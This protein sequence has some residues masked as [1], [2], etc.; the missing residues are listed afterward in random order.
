MKTK[1]FKKGISLIALVATI[2]IIGILLSAIVIRSRDILTKTSKKEFANELY[3]V[4]SQVEKYYFKNSEYPISDSIQIDLS[5]IED[6]DVYQFKEEQGYPDGVI[7]LYKIDL[8]EADVDEAKRGTQDSGS[9]DV[10]AVSQDTGNIYY[11]AGYKSG[12][13]TFY[14]LTDDLLDLI[15]LNK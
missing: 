2:V 1:D 7:T 4:E 5:S 8:Y 14:T 3:L 15:D 13:D 6:R 10:Y 11:V 12:Y 9:K